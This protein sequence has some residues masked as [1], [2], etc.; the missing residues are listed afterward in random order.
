MKELNVIIIPEQIQNNEKIAL[1]MF[2]SVRLPNNP[3]V[4][5]N[6]CNCSFIS[7]ALGFFVLIIVIFVNLIQIMKKRLYIKV[8][9]S[10]YNPT[11]MLFLVN[12]YD[13]I[14]IAFK[15]WLVAY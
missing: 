9:K 14:H 3:S 15:L 2:V 4:P 5:P 7:L 11:H 12:P 6:H 10:T 8:L 13:I 1:F